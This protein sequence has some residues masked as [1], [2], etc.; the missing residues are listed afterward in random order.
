MEKIKKYDNLLVW[1]GIAIFSAVII[2]QVPVS[3]EDELWNFQNI[4]KMVNG[5]TIY[6]DA[7]VIITPIFFFNRRNSF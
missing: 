2:F 7:N 1:I 5:Y 3:A 4:Y 6:Q